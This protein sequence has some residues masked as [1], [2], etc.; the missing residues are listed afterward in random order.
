MG[1]RHPWQASRGKPMGDPGA[2]PELG[3]RNAW[4]V[5]GT[6]VGA[7][8]LRG[9][10]RVKLHNP[11]SELLSTLSHVTLRSPGEPQRRVA[12][13]SARAHAKDIWWIA[14]EGCDER[15]QAMQLRDAELCVTRA[16]LPA[17]PEG[18]HYLVDLI[19]LCV[20]LPDGRA[21]GRVDEVL[22]YPAACVLRVGVEAGVIEVPLLPPYV[23]EIR[24]AEGSVIVDQIEDLEVLPP[25]KVRRH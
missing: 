22:E 17:L 14:L 2:A 12:L 4:I 21:L 11:A 10:L 7:H 16:E 8:G 23:L 3:D 24:T 6:V 18:E 20:R 25:P 1:G 5:L 19:G 9:E 15:E 13:L